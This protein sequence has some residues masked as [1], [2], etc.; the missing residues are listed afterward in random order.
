KV[1]VSIFD[2]AGRMVRTLATDTFEAGRH[3]VAW[4]QKDDRGNDALSG[5]YYVRMQSNEFTAS[6]SVV[7]SR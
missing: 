2:V 4:D 6:R 7:V 1:S 5:V 3:Q